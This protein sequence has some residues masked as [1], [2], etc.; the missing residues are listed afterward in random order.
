MAQ[1]GLLLEEVRVLGAYH[2]EVKRSFIGGPRPS[3]S[4]GGALHRGDTLTLLPVEVGTVEG[5]IEEG[6]KHRGGI[7]YLEEEVSKIPENQTC[8][9]GGAVLLVISCQNVLSIPKKICLHATT[10]HQNLILRGI[11]LLERHLFD[12]KRGRDK[13]VRL[14]KRLK[15]PNLIPLW[16][17]Q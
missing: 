17:K 10:V 12:K 4:Q 1:G 13:I 8:H 2:R 9:V 11:V 6:V 15:G 3:L 7:F 14:K 16:N 5:R